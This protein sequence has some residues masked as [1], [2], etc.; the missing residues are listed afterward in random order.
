MQ[1]FHGLTNFGATC[2]LNS[3]VQAYINCPIIQLLLNF[4]YQDSFNTQSD[5]ILFALKEL[6]FRKSYQITKILDPVNICNSL[7]VIGDKLY[8][9]EDANLI[10]KQISEAF[11]QVFGP[12][13]VFIGQE[14]QTITCKS[15]SH[16]NQSLVTY[17]D[18]FLQIKGCLSSAFFQ[19]LQPEDLDYR[20]QCKSNEQSKQQ[21]YQ[22]FPDLLIITFSRFIFNENTFQFIKNENSCEIIQKIDVKGLLCYKN[23]SEEFIK[24]TLQPY[25]YFTT[26]SKECLDEIIQVPELYNYIIE[27]YIDN[28]QV[29]E[30]VYQL[31]S[32]VC[33]TGNISSGHYY[34]YINK[35][36]NLEEEH[37]YEFNDSFVNKIQKFPN[38]IGSNAYMCYYVNIN[39]CQQ[40]KIDID[41]FGSEQ[42]KIQINQENLEESNNVNK[43]D[44]EL[45]TNHQSCDEF[46]ILN[47]QM[48]PQY[49]FKISQFDSNISLQQFLEQFNLPYSQA[50][51]LYQMYNTSDV[52]K[53]TIRRYS[54]FANQSNL[55]DKLNCFIQ[56]FKLPHKTSQKARIFI[57]Y[58]CQNKSYDFKAC[59][60]QFKLLKENNILKFVVI[61]INDALFSQEDYSYTIS[62]QLFENQLLQYFAHDELVQYELYQNNCLHIEN[63]MKLFNGDVISIK[64]IPKM[65]KI[66]VKTHFITK[67]YTFNVKQSEIEI[68]ETII[69]SLQLGNN[70]TYRIH[71]DENKIIIEYIFRNK[72]QLYLFPQLD[73]VDIFF[74]DNAT[75][76]HILQ[77]K[78]IKLLAPNCVISKSLSVKNVLKT[79]QQ[80]QEQKYILVPHGEIAIGYFQRQIK[81]QSKFVEIVILKKQQ[82]LIF[83]GIQTSNQDIKEHD[84]CQ[85]IEKATGEIVL[86][87]KMNDDKVIAIL[88]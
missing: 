27:N 39:K 80:L 59:Y 9:Q 2:Y 24:V 81:Q 86:S 49:Y 78:I 34:T 45:Q 64:I 72:F 31:Q 46:P 33:H 88:K 44:I 84:Y 52:I 67:F 85:F 36:T 63:E 60:I 74:D 26:C 14:Q 35:S 3:T 75:V 48:L 1:K 57:E 38:S 87:I 28:L 50:F 8:E 32:I 4:P 65:Y 62:K 37:F 79:D 7:N 70:D 29:T 43:I 69:N 66:Y 41:N 23:Q 83:T 16:I 47:N 11:E 6:I 30:Y 15:C 10:Q 61:K 77:N 19:K 21:T 17:S 71:I 42:M 13:G 20:C 68:N 51:N 73:Y 40:N 25:I 12:S 82:Q 56:E 53:Q 5:Q 76:G 55:Q 18:I 54:L 58:P 22:K